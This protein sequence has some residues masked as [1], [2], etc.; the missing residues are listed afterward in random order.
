MAGVEVKLFRFGGVDTI[1][2]N[3]LAA[4]GDIMMLI[5]LPSSSS[6]RLCLTIVAR[7]AE[8]LVKGLNIDTGSGARC[9]VVAAQRTAGCT[10]DPVFALSAVV[11][12]RDSMTTGEDVSVPLTRCNFEQV[13]R[14][15]TVAAYGIF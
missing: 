3:R 15:R 6:R 13:M 14:E 4:R 9:D 5:S 7:G 10:R 11:S 8:V 12:L 1:F 2:C